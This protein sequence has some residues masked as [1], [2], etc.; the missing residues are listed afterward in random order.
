MYFDNE[1]VK[2]TISN[3]KNDIFD[4]DFIIPSFPLVGGEYSLTFFIKSEG[5]ISDWIISE[6]FITVLDG[7]YFKNEKLFSSDYAQFVLNYKVDLNEFY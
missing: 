7:V 2:K 5:E 6:V 4:V 3:I 1:F